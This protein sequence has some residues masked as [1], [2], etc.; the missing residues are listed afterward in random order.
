MSYS[1][2]CLRR[3]C[4]SEAAVAGLSPCWTD[5]IWSLQLASKPFRS[6]CIRTTSGFSGRVAVLV[7]SSRMVLLSAYLDIT[8]PGYCRH[9]V[10]GHIL[11]FPLN[12]D[13]RPLLPYHHNLTYFS[14]QTPSSI[15]K[16]ASIHD[17]SSHATSWRIRPF[18]LSVHLSHC[19]SI[20][21]PRYPIII[22]K[23]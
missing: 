17:A 23:L 9:K 22:R 20:D 21:P 6:R 15:S 4:A 7:A 13:Y 1:G 2:R 3:L 19:L 8:N 16:I 5:H 12:V 14:S 10:F 11:S 18:R